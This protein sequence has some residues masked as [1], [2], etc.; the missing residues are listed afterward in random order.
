[1]SNQIDT[2]RL[3]KLLEDPKPSN[4]TYT[5]KYIGVVEGSMGILSRKM[6]MP[7]F[8]EASVYEKRDDYNAYTNQ[9]EE[10]FIYYEDETMQEKYN[11]SKPEHIETSMSIHPPEKPKRNTK[12][13]KFENRNI[14]IDKPLLSNK[15][16]NKTLKNE[17]G[18]NV[19]TNQIIVEDDRSSKSPI[20]KYRDGMESDEET[21]RNDQNY[22]NSD[23]IQEK[24]ENSDNEGMSPSFNAEIHQTSHDSSN[25]YRNAGQIAIVPTGPHETSDTSGFN[26]ERA[27]GYPMP[28]KYNS[29]YVN[30]Y[31]LPKSFA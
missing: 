19:N 18:I 13:G 20:H 17:T 16:N 24:T 21:N 12:Y 14:I 3:N 15:R 8:T 25:A 4:K 1:M 27:S 30:N 31:S 26:N 22:R 5:V 23:M 6:R 10:Q 9:P 28:Q 2:Q 7:K 11:T 29:Y